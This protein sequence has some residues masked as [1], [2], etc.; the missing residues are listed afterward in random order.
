MK[1]KRL[2]FPPKDAPSERAEQQWSQQ[3]GA[4]QVPRGRR[5][6]AA[7]SAVAS[8]TKSAALPSPRI[9]REMTCF[10]SEVLKTWVA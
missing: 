5:D 1:Y 4:D 3:H 7:A 8:C 10:S 6:P 9:W 2:P